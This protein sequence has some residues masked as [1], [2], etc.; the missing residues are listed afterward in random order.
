[1]KSIYK[2]LFTIFVLN[3]VLTEV[4]SRKRIKTRKRPDAATPT[5]SSTANTEGPNYLTLKTDRAFQMDTVPKELA[6]D[7][8][9]SQ[10]IAT[11]EETLSKFAVTTVLSVFG[12]AAAEKEDIEKCQKALTPELRV[13]MM[14]IF[15]DRVK[16]TTHD[17][18]YLKVKK[19]IP[20]VCSTPLGKMWKNLGE[21]SFQWKTLSNKLFYQARRLRK[22][23]KMLE[24]RIARNQKQE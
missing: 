23:R 17:K 18:V 14:H 6:D 12:S 9:Q 22:L 8:L 15:H 5:D 2:I 1:M 16:L 4:L 21:N 10:E 13:V 7:Q 20:A 3:L 24:K 19:Q 11:R